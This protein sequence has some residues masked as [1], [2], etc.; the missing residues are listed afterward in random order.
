M[1]IYFVYYFFIIILGFFL[2]NK[3]QQFF[4]FFSF[5]ILFLVIAFRHP[6][7]G[8]DLHYGSNLGYIGAYKYFSSCSWKKL[9]ERSV[10]SAFEIGF[11]I[12][13]KLLSYVSQ[14][15]QMLLIGTTFFSFCPIFYTIK[16]ESCDS[17]LSLII[18][19]GLPSF[20]MVFSAL[21]QAIA[22]SFV[23]SAIPLIKKKHFFLQL[24]L[25]LF[26]ST[27]HKTSLVFLLAYP[28]YHIKWSS[29]LR[30]TISFCI[31]VLLYCF[32]S[33]L[34]SL[35]GLF[36]GYEVDNNGSNG[37][38]L[39]YS[40]IYFLFS[41][42]DKTDEDR[43]FLNLF[44]LSCCIMCFEHLSNVVSR[45]AMYYEMVLVL[46]IPSLYS[47]HKKESFFLTV[48]TMVCFIVAG[49]YF[50]KNEYWA[51]AFPYHFSWEII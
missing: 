5:L 25:I 17:L 37:L 43:G 12:F 26:A 19:L 46:L 28:S 6:S 50:L 18:Y 38:F 7:M 31:L 21:R 51:M 1:T 49:L 11:V 40:C 14:N 13:N 47:K 48:V 33:R 29:G 32:S 2:K 41:L 4:L 45:L 44:F 35:F 23:F 30:I 9:F 24:L 39:V 8:I 22:I 42:I 34:Y 10:F 16:K 3:K 27:F 20:L 36:V 15:P